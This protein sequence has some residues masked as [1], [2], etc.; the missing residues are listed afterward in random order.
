[1]ANLKRLIRH[2][3]QVLSFE[4]YLEVDKKFTYLESIHTEIKIHF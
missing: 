3:N 2:T 4:D 1:M